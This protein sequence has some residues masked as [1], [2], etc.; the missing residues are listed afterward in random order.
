MGGKIKYWKKFSVL[1]QDYYK[2]NFSVSEN[3]V[4]GYTE[5]ISQNRIKQSAELAGISNKIDNLSKKY[6]TILG[7]EFDGS[8][9]L[10]IGE[11]QKLG[12]S[13]AFYKNAEIIILDEPSAF[14]DPIA[15]H[16]LFEKFFKL[17][18]N[19]ISIF[20][21]H[22]LSGVV[23][24]DK[25][26]FLNDGEILD[27]DSHANLMKNNFVYRDYFNLQAEKYNNQLSIKENV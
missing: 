1:F 21:S 18:E 27:Y 12:L 13:R 25:I 14:L 3:I 16:D 4:A 20:V 17:N 23:K 2:F 6:D 9:E 19:K 10:S 24:A 26:L 11:W 22:R 5:N 15:E 7:K 8:Q